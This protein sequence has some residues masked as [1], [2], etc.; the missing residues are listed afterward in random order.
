MSAYKEIAKIYDYLMANVDYDGWFKNYMG[1]LSLGGPVTHLLELGCGTGNFTYRLAQHFDVHA[2]DLSAEML[3][4]AQAKANQFANCHPVT[5][6]CADMAT[7][8]AHALGPDVQ[9]D[10]AVA[11]FDVLNCLDSAEKLN[12]VCAHVARYLKTGARFVFDVN[13]ELAFTLHLFDETVERPEE[14]YSHVWRGEYDPNSRLEQVKMRYYD[15][16]EP[17][18]HEEHTQRAHS[19]AEITHALTSAGFDHIYF[20]DAVTM[21]QPNENTDRWL[22]ACRKK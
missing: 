11:V 14:G 6:E 13:T 3:A 7:F 8:D 19:R 10:A 9:F 22:I 4:Q 21:N 20:I 16:G 15:N 2:V 18:F 12:T 17:A 1:L 5:F